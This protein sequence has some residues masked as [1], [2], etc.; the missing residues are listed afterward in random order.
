MGIHILDHPLVKH[1]IGL[2]R[3]SQLS[4]MQFRAVTKELCQIL[5]YEST[6]SLPLE[7]HTVQGWSGPISVDYV[8]GKMLTVVPILRAGFCMLEG[9]FQVIPGAKISTV[10]MFRDEKSLTP[11]NYYINFVHALEQRL[12]IILDPMLATGGTICAV[13]NLLKEK[14]CKQIC[15][16]FLFSAPEGIDKVQKEHPDIDI[17]TCVVDK[18]LDKNGY[19]IP[20]VGDAGDR[21]FGTNS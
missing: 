3:D 15:G 10:G 5:T 11:F 12:A 21:L 7:N 8:S 6:Q 13:A 20:G 14:G 4:I 2:L 18:N 16:L 9:F 1:K 17:Y 19:I